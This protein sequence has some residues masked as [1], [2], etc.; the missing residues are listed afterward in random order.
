MKCSQYYHIEGMANAHRCK[1]LRSFNSFLKRESKL[2]TTA[3]LTV[4]V[5][6]LL[7]RT[8][9]KECTKLTC[10]VNSLGKMK[11]LIYLTSSILEKSH[12]VKSSVGKMPCITFSIVLIQFQNQQ[13]ILFF[14]YVEK[15]LMKNKEIAIYF[16]NIKALYR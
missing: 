9:F 1:M 11:Y 8:N 4:S 16:I 5:F 3:I 15:K 13:V 14:S 6:V 7:A 2:D 12:C 10:N